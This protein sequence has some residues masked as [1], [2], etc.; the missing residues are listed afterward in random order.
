MP[1]SRSVLAAGALALGL[2]LTP[3]GSAA[4]ADGC[5][6]EV[7]RMTINGIDVRNGGDSGGGELYGDVVFDDQYLWSRSRSDAVRVPNGPLDIASA[8]RWKM[9]DEKLFPTN[10]A[11]GTVFVVK[12]D[13]WDYDYVSGD[14]RVAVGT[15]TVDPL[16]EGE[17]RHQLDYCYGSSC[18]EGQTVIT[19]TLELVGGCT[20]GQCVG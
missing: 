16:Q 18:S 7:W 2:A 6:T 4:A 14:D 13:L 9:W 15:R 10:G 3:A 19:Y 11:T 20:S 5:G 12:A 1:T 17:G 8:N